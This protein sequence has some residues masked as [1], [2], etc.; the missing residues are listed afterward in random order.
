[1]LVA[2]AALVSDAPAPS[3]VALAVTPAADPSPPR[4]ALAA[5]PPARASLWIQVGA[6]RETET[7]SRLVESLRAYSV[8]MTTGGGRATPLTRVLVGPFPDR[9]AAALVV[10]ELAARGHRAFIALE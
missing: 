1:V 6:F 8:M 4:Q 9:T 7:A 2:S 3:R 5:P 10:K